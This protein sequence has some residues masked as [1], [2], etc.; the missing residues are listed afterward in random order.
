MSI[1]SDL[2]W[3]LT[4]MVV[5]MGILRFWVQAGCLRMFYNTKNLQQTRMRRNSGSPKGKME[6]AEDA[7][8]DA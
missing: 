2:A 1:I 5:R 8:A 6:V 4:A 3:V 7:S